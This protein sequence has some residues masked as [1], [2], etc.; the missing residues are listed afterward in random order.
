M[1]YICTKF[2]ENILNGLRIMQPT[3]FLMD[4]QTDIYGR[5]GNIISKP[6]TFDLK[7]ISLRVKKFGLN[8]YY[9]VFYDLT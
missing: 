3:Q 8:V 7:G 5:G 1:V 4:R 2:G 6:W 9:A